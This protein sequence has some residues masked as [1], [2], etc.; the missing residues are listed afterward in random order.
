MKIERK[1]Y[2]IVLVSILLGT[3][4]LSV[5]ATRTF[6]DANDTWTGTIVQSGNTDFKSGVYF[7][8]SKK[9]YNSKGHMWNATGANLYL[10]YYD[11][12]TTGG[13][14][15]LPVCN[16]TM[17]KPLVFVNNTYIKGSGIG[18]TILYRAA[19]WNDAMFIC[20]WNGD[21]A[22][23][24]GGATSGRHHVK[25]SDMTLD[26]NN[27]S[28]TWSQYSFIVGISANSN[29]FTFV[30]MLFRRSLTDMIWMWEFTGQTIGKDTIVVDRCTFD[31]IEYYLGDYPAGVYF[32]GKNCKC[33]NSHFIDCWACGATFENWDNPAFCQYSIIEDCTF[34]GCMAQGI[35]FEGG[36]GSNN[37]ANNNKIHDI[38]SNCY[39][40]AQG[41]TMC[42]GISVSQLYSKVEGNT[43]ANLEGFGISGGSNGYTTIQGNT[44]INIQCTDGVYTHSG[45]PTSMCG[46]GILI[47]HYSGTYYTISGNTITNCEKNGTQVS[48]RNIVSGNIIVGGEIGIAPQNIYS[49]WSKY[50]MSFLNNQLYSQS[51][52]GIYLYNSYDCIV[53]GNQ[54]HNTPLGINLSGSTTRRAIILGNNLVGCTTA[55]YHATLTNCQYGYN[56]TG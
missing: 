41:I 35:C 37:S 51:V 31:S 5:F 16:L 21:S 34:T 22:A 20:G 47:G 14:L 56:V 3:G 52:E 18:A 27:V 28:N 49:G 19:G 55:W 36:K 48:N 33:T 29:N 7:N 46:I 4:I 15:Y 54:I 23:G 10:A 12:N 8:L 17:T 6:T 13:T 43:I 50:N 53:S 30:D 38:E 32:N 44:I 26:G 11:M 39:S 1:I 42:R 2:A 45:G 9:I 40:Y 25:M 24:P